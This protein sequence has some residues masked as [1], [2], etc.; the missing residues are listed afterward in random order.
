MM[1]VV[2]RTRLGLAAARRALGR[3]I[4]LVPTMGALREGHRVLI[5]HAR[6]IA[7]PNGSVVV[8]IFVNP[9]Q[10]GAVRTWTVTRAPWTPT[11]WSAPPKAST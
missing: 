6:D 1:P 2:A 3:P 10:V 7:T 9:L 11:C 5:R 8:S 4:V